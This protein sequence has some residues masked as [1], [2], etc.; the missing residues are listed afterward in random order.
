MALQ[1][2]PSTPSPAT[3]KGRAKTGGRTKG[4]PNKRTIGKQK[5]GFGIPGVDPL[6]FGLEILKANNI[7]LA[8]RM[9]AMKAVL[10]YTHSK[11]P[12]KVE[13]V[14]NTPPTPIKV[15]IEYKDA[16]KKPE[17]KP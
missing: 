16:R 1:K 14:D 11:M 3:K 9:D 13:Q 6:K 12:I 4:T 2:P 7:P 5:L 17:E 10:P 8:F 15:S